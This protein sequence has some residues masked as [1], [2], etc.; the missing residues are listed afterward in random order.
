[1]TLEPR[2]LATANKKSEYQTCRLEAYTRQCVLSTAASRTVHC[3]PQSV[4]SFETYLG[5]TI[6]ADEHLQHTVSIFSLHNPHPL[7]CKD[8][9]SSQDTLPFKRSPLFLE[10]GQEVHTSLPTGVLSLPISS[11]VLLLKPKELQ[12]YKRRQWPSA[13]PSTAQATAATLLGS[14]NLGNPP[15]LWNWSPAFIHFKH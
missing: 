9:W 15:L 4:G 7:L 11:S 3:S 12:C 8:L 14:G 10:S 5:P 2:W 1:M 6:Y 13:F